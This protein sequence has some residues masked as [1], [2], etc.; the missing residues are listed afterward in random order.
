MRRGYLNPSGT[1]M[2]FNFSSPLDM[3][4]V[5]GKYMRI[6]YG[7]GECQ[8]RPHPAPLPCLNEVRSNIDP[9]KR[10]IYDFNNTT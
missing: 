1:G 10:R 2:R 8:T 9:I 7:D 3:G 4:R 5:T 6:G